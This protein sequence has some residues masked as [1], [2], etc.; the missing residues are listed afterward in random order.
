AIAT[1]G[2]VEACNAAAELLLLVR[3][4]LLF[5]RA[6]CADAFHLDELAVRAGIALQVAVSAA[7]GA[8][9]L[10]ITAGA[11]ASVGQRL[12]GV[13]RSAGIVSDRASATRAAVHRVATV[14]S[15]AVR[16]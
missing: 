7:A 14:A 5:G 13:M 15:A 1:A 3:H 4:A 2:A 6:R 12:A 10:D 8:R 9:V 11:R 16:S